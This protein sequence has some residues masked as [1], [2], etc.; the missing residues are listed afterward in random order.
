[1]KGIIKTLIDITIIATIATGF[2]YGMAALYE[3]RMNEMAT[4]EVTHNCKYD[5]NGL[6]YTESERPWLFDECTKDM[7]AY[8][9]PWLETDET[10]CTWAGYE[11]DTD[12]DCERCDILVETCRL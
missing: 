1:M 6:C 5:S 10:P 2:V 12:A 11:C 3:K 7:P 9:K 8:N 4:Y